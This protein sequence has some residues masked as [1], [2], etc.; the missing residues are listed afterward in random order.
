MS[1]EE[2][3][4]DGLFMSAIQ[5]SNGIST[6]YEHLFSFMRR[7]TDFF[8]QEEESVKTVNKIMEKHMDLFRADKV[9]QEVIAQK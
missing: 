1:G 9:R 6:F 8:S 5:Q 4:F 2:Q 7:K 3:R